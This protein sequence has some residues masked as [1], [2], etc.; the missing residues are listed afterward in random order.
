MHLFERE[1]EGEGQLTASLLGVLRRDDGDGR[2]LGTAAAEVVFDEQLQVTRQEV[3]F[4][5]QPRHPHL[6]E[7]LGRGGRENE[8]REFGGYNA[9]GTESSSLVESIECCKL[10]WERGTKCQDRDLGC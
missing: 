7:D 9:L 4:L 8:D 1:G 3:L 6:V 5:Q 10:G 2:T